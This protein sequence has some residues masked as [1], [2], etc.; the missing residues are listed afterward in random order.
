M[1]VVDLREFIYYFYRFFFSMNKIDL[2]FFKH[3]K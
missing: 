2:K 3:T 1:R